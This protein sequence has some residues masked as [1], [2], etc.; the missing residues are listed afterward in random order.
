MRLFHSTDTLGRC[1]EYSI[2]RSGVSRIE[3]LVILGCIVLGVALALPWL[4]KNREA[5][6]AGTCAAR[7]FR[8]ALAI[9]SF[10]NEYLSLPGYRGVQMVA[11]DGQ[12]QAISWVYPTLPYLVPLSSAITLVGSEGERT[13]DGYAPFEQD[14]G[15]KL[16]FRPTNYLDIFAR[17]SAAGDPETRG[18]TPTELI[19]E[20]QCP[21][22]WLEVR[23]QPT[24][25]R[26]FL[27]WRVA[28]GFPDVPTASPPDWP[29]SALFVDR[30][31]PD[32]SSG[33]SLQNVEAWDGISYTVL[34]A[35]TTIPVAWPESDE[36]AV[37]LVAGWAKE[38]TAGQ[39]D[40][41]SEAPGTTTEPNGF[42]LDSWQ[43]AGLEPSP[44]SR[45]SDRWAQAGSYHA[46]GINVT[47]GDGSTREFT[48][49]LDPRIWI[50]MIL[51]NDAAARFPGTE[52]RV[53]PLLP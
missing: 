23:D 46:T 41:A 9:Q 20:L 12:P 19:P 51:P 50:E 17:Y 7:Q 8:T 38:R 34:F 47:F 31:V 3:I 48:R 33:T 42:D 30:L 29:E 27:S 2:D 18:Q 36:H 14:P 16:V 22:M 25:P 44:G 10:E 21:A 52:Q 53:R 28:S 32:G 39:G 15:E 13:L 26:S 1:Q 11:A 40:A 43:W 37:G 4:V 45:T 6:R 5:A 24:I 35:E 49:D